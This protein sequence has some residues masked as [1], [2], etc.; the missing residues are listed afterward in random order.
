[1]TYNDTDYAYQI[2]NS[3]LINQY[4][5]ELELMLDGEKLELQKEKSGAWTLKH[6]DNTIDPKLV[7]AL[8]RSVSLRLRV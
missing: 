7:Q 4:T 3:R 2:I 1:M 5:T 6:Q 8:V